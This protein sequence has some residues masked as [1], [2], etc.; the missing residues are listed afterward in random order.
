MI[1]VDLSQVML[2]NL[3]VNMA[4]HSVAVD[5]DL[6]RHMIL[7][8]IRSYNVKFGKEYGELVIACDAGNNWRK[9]F[10]PYYKANRKKNRDQSKLDWNAIFTSINKIRDELK[11]YFP[12]RVLHVDGCEADDII[13]VLCETYGAE[14]GGEPILIMSGDKDFQQLQTYSNVNQY[15]PVRKKKIM[16]NDSYGFYLEHVMRGD[17]GDG[18]PNFLSPDDVFVSNGRQKPL[19]SKKVE[20]WIKQLKDGIE[21]SVVF[22]NEQYR[23]WIRNSQ[24]INLID[25][26]PKDLRDTILLQYE[27]ET[28]K[29]RAKLFNYFIKHKLKNLMDVIGEF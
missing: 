20:G 8:S 23:N 29:S 15:D 11:E 10:F 19:S 3:M 4:G 18:I 22:D 17:V 7:N 6:L 21:P 1:L 16:C 14:L 9:S 27:N 26:T 13:G 28:G 2:S 24:L 12:Y 25:T 5:E